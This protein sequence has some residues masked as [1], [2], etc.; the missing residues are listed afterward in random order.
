M[1]HFEFQG[2]YLLLDLPLQVHGPP[3]P[4]RTL[5][6]PSAIFTLKFPSRS[7]VLATPRVHCETSLRASSE[8]PVL[9]SKKALHGVEHLHCCGYISVCPYRLRLLLPPGS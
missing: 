5:P 9:V 8:G 2:R 6:G 1:R 4:A 3:Q 7:R